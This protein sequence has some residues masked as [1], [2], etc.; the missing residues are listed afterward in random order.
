MLIYS[1][2][3]SSVFAGDGDNDGVDS[4]FDCDDSDASVGAASIVYYPDADA[5]GFGSATSSGVASCYV[6]PGYT[7]D[8]TDCDDG[9][10]NAFPGSAHNDSATACMLDADG[11][12]FG[13][14]DTASLRCFRME[15]LS[16][17]SVTV[18]QDSSS[19]L[20][21]AQ[22]F[23]S[24]EFCTMATNIGFTTVSVGDGI[25]LYDMLDGNLLAWSDVE[26]ETFYTV[27]D[28]ASGTDC[29]DNDISLLGTN[30]D[31]DCDG[32]A[33]WLDCDDN[34]AFSTTTATDI[35]CDGVING[36]DLDAD[37]DGQ[38]DNGNGDI[39]TDADCDGIVDQGPT[40]LDGDGV[41][42]DL[43]CDDDDVNLGS[44]ADDT[45][46]D[47]ILNDSDADADGDGL[48]DSTQTLVL[49]DN[50]CDGIENN[51][52][53]DAD[54]DGLCDSTQTLV[55]DDTD[56]DGVSNSVDLDADGDGQCDNGNG[57][58]S[59]DTDCDGVIDSV[60]PTAIGQLS[61]GDLIVTEIMHK[62]ALRTGE[63]KYTEWFEVYNN[64]N[65]AI[66]LDGLS[67]YDDEGSVTI[68]G[69]YVVEAGAY[70][71]FL[72]RDTF[73]TT[74]DEDITFDYYPFHKTVVPGGM[75][76]DNSDQICLD[77]DSDTTN[78][79]FIDCVSWDFGLNGWGDGLFDQNED[80]RVSLS[81]N[82]DSY[83]ALANDISSNWIEG[84]TLFGTFNERGTPGAANDTIATSSSLSLGDLIFTEVMVNPKNEAGSA[85]NNELQWAEIY[86]NSSSIIN[87]NGVTFES[88]ESDG[89]TLSFTVGTDILVS[90]NSYYVLVE[91]SSTELG[92]GVIDNRL[93]YNSVTEFNVEQGSNT[94][95]IKDAN[96]VDVDVLDYYF[97]GQSD[98]W[99]A[100]LGQ[101][102]ELQH[103]NY[104]S[105]DNLLG[106]CVATQA[107]IPSDAYD[108]VG[109]PG[110]A[111]AACD[112]SDSNF[113]TVNNASYWLLH[114][115]TDS[116][117]VAA[118]YDCDD[119]DP[120]IG[121]N[122]DDTDCDQIP[123]DIDLDADGDGVC[124]DTQTNVS[125][126]ADCDGVLDNSITD[127]DG[128][129]VTADLDCD[130]DDVNLGS[131]ADDT[132]CD[133]IL[134]DTDAD[135]D[136]DGQCDSTQTL[137]LDDNDCD[138]IENNLDPDADGD[139][140]CDNGNGDISTD[141]D[142]DTVLTDDDCDDSDPGSTA[143][144]DDIDC[145]GILNES[146]PDADGDGVCD[147][148][149]LST[150][151][152]AD[153]DGIANA[154]DLDADGDGTCDSAGT[155][156]LEDNDCDG[157]L[158][159]DDC[160]DSDPTSFPAAAEV[161]DGIDNNCDL[162]I[163]EGVT[164]TVY[165]D[166]DS[167]GFGVL[168]SPTQECPEA[169]QDLIDAG[170]HSVESTDC[171]DNDISIYP[172]APEIY[173]DGIDQDCDLSDA[174]AVSQA[175]LLEGQLVIT[176]IMHNPEQVL[177]FRGEWFEIFNNTI[178]TVTLN[179]LVVSD[180]SGSS[181]TIPSDVIIGA[182]DY[183]VL[184]A[185]STLDNG[186]IT[187][188]DYAYGSNSG[189][190]SLNN[191]DDITLTS[192]TGTILDSVSWTIISPYPD[193]VSDSD[194]SLGASLSLVSIS[195]S[196][197]D[198]GKFW[199]EATSPYGLGDLGTPGS[200]NDVYD[201]DGDG[202]L[203]SDGDCDVVDASVYTG[204]PEILG[205]GIDQDCDGQDSVAVSSVNPGDI[206]F[207]E[208]MHAPN[209]DRRYAQYFELYNTTSDYINLK[210]LSFEGNTNTDPN[211]GFTV[212][213]DLIVEPNGYVLFGT[214]FN[215]NLNGGLDNIDYRYNQGSTEGRYFLRIWS[216][217]VTLLDENDVVIDT[218]TYS[219]TLGFPAALGSSLE[220]QVLDGTVNDNADAWCLGTQEYGGNSNKGTPGAANSVCTESTAWQLLSDDDGDGVSENQGDCDDSDIAINPG[221]DEL[222]DSVDNDCD[223]EV[224]EA[225]AVDAQIYYDDLDGDGYGDPATGV[226]SCSAPVSKT[227][228]NADCDDSSAT[229][230]PG[231]AELTSLIDCLPDSDDDGY[232]P[233]A[234]GGTDCDDTRSDTYVG[235]REACGDGVDND[236]DPATDEALLTT[237]DFI[238]SDT[239]GVRFLGEQ[240]TDF[241]AQ[242]A[243]GVG[244]LNGDGFNDFAVSAR[245]N[246][247]A[248][249]R[250][251]AIYVFFSPGDSGSPFANVVS[252]GD[253]DVIIT[254]EAT[255]DFAGDVISGADDLLGF[256]GNLNGIGND[257]LL[258]TA[259]KQNF[260]NG[261]N[262]G[263]FYIIEGA[264]LVS[265][266]DISLSDAY[267]AR[268]T[269]SAGEWLGLSASVVGDVN[270]DGAVDFLVSNREND[271][272]S[273]WDGAVYLFLGP[274]ADGEDEA[275]ESYASAIKL[276]APNASDMFGFNVA[277]LGDV[278]GDDIDDVGI[279]LYNANPNGVNQGSEVYI[280][281]G[282]DG[283]L[284]SWSVG[285][286]D[287]LIAGDEVATKLRVVAGA[288]DVD[289][290]GDNDVLVGSSQYNTANGAVWLFSGISSGSYLLTDATAKFVAP[291][292]FGVSSAFG[293]SMSTLGDIN[294]D[295]FADVV[296]G[297]KAAD[298][299]GLSNNGAAFV[300]YGPLQGTYEAAH[301]IIRGGA[302]GEEAGFS[303][304]AVSGGDG[305]YVLVGSPKNNGNT[306][307]LYSLRK[308]QLQ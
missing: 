132:D 42:A 145:D 291:S 211:E 15:L 305:T 97:A 17:A 86:N 253:A 113:A 76:L 35:D 98:R 259:A 118:F 64:T 179:G 242:M 306:G 301:G 190:I 124:D 256:S 138:G 116:D 134:N 84:G 61:T 239:N 102:M 287:I 44:S 127:T 195:A 12:G 175:D 295:G 161:C 131:S 188:V 24:I 266:T 51:L 49:D 247:N 7:T 95:S 297:S 67:V 269:G 204:A 20:Y 8:N 152:D 236:C 308:N 34:D 201:Y 57:D 303:V 16:G 63:E 174:T 235:S 93:T 304:A 249:D 233:T 45:D 177:D 70:F 14:A 73:A 279:V 302:E 62:P 245:F 150:A 173:N 143:V 185:R 126:D 69:T 56:C 47:G 186:E 83:D 77:A 196:D 286:P 166:S 206:I 109:T 1:L 40:D 205:D 208:I 141:A 273:T 191:T 228:D 81:L 271:A 41:T 122:A 80:H 272:G 37:G 147:D 229:T 243:R 223:D 50:D 299:D 135:A 31:A 203:S 105:N 285:S 125:E 103:L 139:G 66:D 252:V 181:F 158:S 210:D 142:C 163:D 149:G 217:T 19:Y 169:A 117:T 28:P 194:P 307:Q 241:L 123:N 68:S 168:N 156:V 277:G 30:V 94:L 5:D 270:N 154:S 96:G 221:A 232:A 263:A 278:N 183:V 262:D 27:A 244:D 180:T 99:R 72:A 71:T 193:A 300:Y 133:G 268:F 198:I 296:I 74:I 227:L 248:G 11:D 55:L 289:G 212:S 18:F 234:S 220:L 90:P 267:S 260:A 144:T 176:E 10:P 261:T 155:S 218:V 43:D 82:A 298:S 108:N 283:G 222:C 231:A 136:G 2:F 157:S 106:W 36:I 230:F 101:S 265:G 153:C 112:A 92:L 258:I 214:I 13:E 100:G 115:D 224:D 290:D 264:D 54:G 237:C 38:C 213:E 164:T 226:G 200:A 165:A 137:V 171:N 215:T 282:V 6:V 119:D 46:C 130:D 29:D 22:G 197:N 292:A 114:T 189:G 240:S 146:D 284:P 255:L 52:D 192:S 178:D 104:M 162:V 58:I 238:T 32:S 121:S 39:S 3:V 129:G 275:I 160:D 65:N 111:N 25:H 148:S 276:T 9:D 91:N 199:V 288:G 48:C 207:S 88:V 75:A 216:D 120:N 89:T 182:N 79:V 281:F 225:D 4:Y 184:A 140:A 53:P 159:V 110:S 209:G 23:S 26:N 128:D 250:A 60:G 151:D 107:Y 21:S 87:L 187:Q 293:Q 202:Q 251:G 172:G 167:D 280:F 78:Q 33:H 59:T 254:G 170:T 85:D 274:I 294:S 219:G 246:D 257:D